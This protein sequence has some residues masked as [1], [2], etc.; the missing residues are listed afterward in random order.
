MSASSADKQRFSAIV[1]SKFEETVLACVHKG[2]KMALGR[3]SLNLIL[4]GELMRL[5]AAFAIRMGASEDGVANMARGC[6]NEAQSL[7]RTLPVDF[8]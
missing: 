8:L 2:H 7:A 6:Y 1:R 5:G 3:P 4:A